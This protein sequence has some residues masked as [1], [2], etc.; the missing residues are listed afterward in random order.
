M[1]TIFLILSII[2][3]AFSSCKKK[4]SAE[5]VASTTGGG[6]VV[7]GNYGVFISRKQAII[8]N[9]LVS[10]LSNFSTAF[11][12]NTALI[13][14][15]PI[16][17]SL[18]NMGDVTL[19]GTTFQHNGF[20][21][22][23]MYK[24]STSLTYNT[25]LNWNITGSVSVSSFSFSNTNPYPVYTGYSS[26]PDSFNISSNVSI[27]LV[28][29]SG[30]DEIETYFISSGA[31]P[32][33]TSIQHITGSPSSLNF[34]VSDLSMIGVSSNVSLAITFYKNNMQT[35]NGKQYNFR[36]GYLVIKSNLKFK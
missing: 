2:A 11:V 35:I 10:N 4:E 18:V 26:V 3:I 19:N 17:G 16:V 28:S 20:S 15:N 14:N 23:N 30:S 22:A 7:S 9:T 21:V 32:I 25:P 24:D 27:P 34:T 5:P 12:S 29:Y 36:T 1:K 31:A 33:T 13:D 6:I 8:T